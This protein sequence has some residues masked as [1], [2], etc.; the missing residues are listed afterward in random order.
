MRSS[1]IAAAFAKFEQVYLT[2]TLL[3][4]TLKPIINAPHSN[5]P[6]N[7]HYDHHYDYVAITR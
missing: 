4:F 7:H 1:N 6:W 2:L 5:V 3:D